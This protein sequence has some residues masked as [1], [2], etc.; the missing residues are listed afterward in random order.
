MKA[1]EIINIIAVILAFLSIVSL[2]GYSL[3]MVIYALPMKW[4][5]FIFA[6]MIVSEL[7]SVIT[8]D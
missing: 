4:Y 2:A 8:K 3:A 1:K 7:I 6:T 5:W